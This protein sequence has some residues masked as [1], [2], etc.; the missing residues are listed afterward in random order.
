MVLC[1]RF[2]S[3]NKRFSCRIW[4]TILNIDTADS[5]IEPNFEF[6]K[7]MAEDYKDLVYEDSGRKFPKY[8]SK[9]GFTG[10]Q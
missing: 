6:Q 3:K 8:R 7:G 10:R 4:Y 1:K 2:G 9:G 5:L